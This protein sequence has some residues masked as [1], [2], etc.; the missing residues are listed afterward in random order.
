MICNRSNKHEI[1]KV[2]VNHQLKQ[3]HMAKSGR[4]AEI[5]SAF[6]ARLFMI[7]DQFLP[8]ALVILNVSELS[9]G[10]RRHVG[11]ARKARQSGEQDGPNVRANNGIS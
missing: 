5:C 1:S 8:A 3:L 11:S 2:R 7:S 9:A 6:Y 4:A 10:T